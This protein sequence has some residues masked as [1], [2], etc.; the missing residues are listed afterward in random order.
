MKHIISQF[1]HCNLPYLF[2]IC[3]KNDSIIYGLGDKTVTLYDALYPNSAIENLPQ[4]IGNLWG[5][6]DPK[7]KFVEAIPPKGHYKGSEEPGRFS[8]RNLP[9]PTS[10]NKFVK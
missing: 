5:T 2:G 4:E 6:G 8:K 7:Q 10:G 1:S 3:S 9:K